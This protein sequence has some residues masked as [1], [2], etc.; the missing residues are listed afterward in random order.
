MNFGV[1]MQTNISGNILVATGVIYSPGWVHVAS[2]RNKRSIICQMKQHLQSQLMT[3][4]GSIGDPVHLVD[5]FPLPVCHFRRAKHCSRFKGSGSYGYC[6]SKREAYFGFEGHL[7][8]DLR[9]VIAGFT[10][11]P[12]NESEREAVWAL[13][14]TVR[15]GLLLGDKGYL[16]AAFQDELLQFRQ[17]ELEAPV[18]HNMQDPLTKPWRNCLNRLRRRVETTIGQLG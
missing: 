18:R 14:D 6:A 17:I 16:G 9:G 12:A 4:L 1:T 11:T 8:V 13:T 15:G 7:L 10:L 5:G 2:L 3:E